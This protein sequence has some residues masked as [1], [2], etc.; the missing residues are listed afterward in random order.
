VGACHV[1]KSENF[2]TQFWAALIRNLARRRLIILA[3][4]AAEFCDGMFTESTDGPVI[5]LNRVGV[6][7]G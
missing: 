3:E 2:P 7:F 6:S 1:Y 4:D 5:Q